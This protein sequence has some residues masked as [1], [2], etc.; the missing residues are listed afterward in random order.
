[1]ARFSMI[2]RENRNISLGQ[3]VKIM[4]RIT[5]LTKVAYIDTGL[6]VGTSMERG[7][8]V[9]NLVK[10]IVTAQEPGYTV[11]N[12]DLTL[13]LH[14]AERTIASLRNPN[15][16]SIDELVQILKAEDIGCIGH[17]LSAV[18]G[19]YIARLREDGR[20][21]YA[22][23]MAVSMRDWIEL[24]GDTRI[25]CISS[26]MVLR[27]REYLRKLE[28]N[29][30]Q[31]SDATVNKKLQHLKTFVSHA[32]AKGIAIDLSPFAGVKIPRSD[33]DYSV[34]DSSTFC[35]WKSLILPPDSRKV[36]H[37]MWMLTFYLCGANFC[38]IYA[39]DLSGDLFSFS[40]QKIRGVVQKRTVTHIP[41]IP[42]AREIIDRYIG[43]DGRLHFHFAQADAKAVV[44]N[45]GHILRKMRA[46]YGLPDDFKLSTARDTFA[47]YCMEL[48]IPDAVT[49]YLLGHSANR[50]GV[51]SYY[52]KLPPKIAEKYIL[53]VVDYA[54]HPER[55]DDYIEEQMFRGVL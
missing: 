44:H 25:E 42:Q 51:M 20:D 2:W 49:D 11:L 32:K 4:L 10:G 45:L 35:R 41:I 6:T 1:M 36:V 21:S 34:V 30:R 39:A 55:Y 28:R 23:M 53:R 31:L 26:A 18:A 43:E 50:R 47:Q 52:S 3:R 9:V 13:M 14:R 7:K 33:A 16:I 40:R 5:H 24:F 17:N 12:A 54:V 19:N 15:N 38:D 29:G 22:D 37:D 27:W 48:L 8:V 46:E